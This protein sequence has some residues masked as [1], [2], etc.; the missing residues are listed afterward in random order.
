[1]GPKNHGASRPLS[2]TDASS[3]EIPPCLLICCRFKFCRGGNVTWVCLR[4]K[5]YPSCLSESGSWFSHAPLF[6]VSLC[7]FCLSSSTDC[8]SPAPDP[9]CSFRLLR[10]WGMGGGVLAPRKRGSGKFRTRYHISLTSRESHHLH[11]AHFQVYIHTSGKEDAS[12]SL[13]DSGLPVS[14]NVNKKPC[15]C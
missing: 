4:S 14:I 2:W 10:L 9:V 12:R 5:F 13:D 11:S 6:S 7:P 8:V 15:P 3:T 1:M